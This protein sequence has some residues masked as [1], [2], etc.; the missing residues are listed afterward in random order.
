MDLRSPAVTAFEA[1][2]LAG[3]PGT[4]LK[5]RTGPLPKAMVP[6]L[7]APLLEHQIALC[8]RHGITRILLLVH[9][10]HE[11]IRAHFGDGSA[12][13]VSLGYAVEQTP[14]GTGGALGDALPLLLDTF[15]V[16][17]GD[18]Y[19]EVDLR[20]MWE[21]HASRGADVT[22]FA[23][24][25]DHPCD[26]DLVELDAQGF[27]TALHPY[28]HSERR[29]HHN[30]VN[31]ALY[32]IERRALEGTASPE[33]PSD[34]ARHTLPAMLKAGRR[35]F[36]YVSPEYIKDIGTPDRLDQVERDI[37]A[38]VPE[39]LSGRALRPA[40]FL[41]RDGTLN[42]EVHHLDAAE[43]VELL[44]GVATALRRLNHAGHLAV[45]ITNQPVVARGAVTAEGLERIHARLTHM[46]GRAG[47]YLDAIYACPHHPESGFPGEVPEL[48]VQCEC[49]KPR[50]GSIDAACRDLMVDRRASWLV[51]DSTADIE[52]GRRAGLKTILVRTGYA[53]QDGKYPF[54][55]DY[56]V[57]DLDAAVSW[58]L[59]G[60]PLICRRTAPVAVAALGAR[61]VLIGGLARSGKSFVA[62]VLKE[63]VQ[64]FG[65]TAHVLP[66][67]SWL[68]PHGE[69]A[70]GTGVTTRFDIDRLVGTVG[71]MV[72]SSDRH[73]LEL[74]IYDR[75]RRTMYDH[76]VH[77]SIGPDDLIIVE[78]V[79]ALIDPYLSKLAGIRVHV[80]VPEPD[81]MA[82]LRAD[83][84]WRG[85]TDAAVDALL[86]SRAVDES[87][88]VRKARD[89]A[90]V[91]VT[92]WT[93]A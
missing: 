84:R 40:V 49:R 43:R 50:T 68:K 9:H 13:G 89:H 67:D 65:R 74:P 32:V 35:V 91:I 19:L 61:V 60:H 37:R 7:G 25:N 86:A 31:A 59:E 80:E 87:E 64:A 14:R 55:P 63:Q 48:K 75:A 33:T 51:G 85:E 6:I 83:Y 56:V 90:N 38:G 58:M 30:L 11:V 36:G 16:L 29:D 52:T 82:R 53:G 46:L 12:H 44:D 81:R 69:R 24:P 45:V 73:V 78:G 79:P 71:P 66:L 10:A 47:A 34:L 5:A 41:D 17:Y 54:R 18:T 76:P 92:A 28:P 1:A 70:E 15:A 77:V 93:G 39:R 3:G 4:R 2:I 22:L 42:R 62:Q 21:A 23:H 27:V 72:A 88:P 8:R 20:R 57:T 26:S